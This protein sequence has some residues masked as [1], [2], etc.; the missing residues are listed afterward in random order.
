[1]NH[2]LA[3][4]TS[5]ESLAVG[6]GERLA[7]GRLLVLGAEDALTPRLAMS[8]L[9]PRVHAL[10]GREGVDLSEVGTVVVGVG[11][12]SFTGVRIAVAT[13]KGL[14]LGLGVPLFGIGTLDAIAWA[15]HAAG[16]RGMLGVVGDAMRGEV[17]PAL[18]RLDDDG[19]A[20]LTPDA[21]SAPDAAASEWADLGEPLLLAGNGLHKYGDIFSEALGDSARMV[22]RGS[23]VPTGCGLLAAFE[24]NERAGALGSGDP[25]ELLPVYTRLADAEEAERFRSG[26]S[27]AVG[28]PA[29]GVIGPDGAS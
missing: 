20:R 8:Q 10:L 9:L 5:T 12:G 26:A 28:S 3:F 13:G 4:D 2:V 21:V 16:E 19:V 22:A 7:D 29:S 23:W 27:G 14:A 25:G 6:L 11:P 17:Y 1:V 15:S 18:Y 24:A